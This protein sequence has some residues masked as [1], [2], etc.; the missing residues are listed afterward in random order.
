MVNLDTAY[1]KNSSVSGHM[2]NIYT[3]TLSGSDITWDLTQ[4]VS[5]GTWIYCI[6][7]TVYINKTIISESGIV[8]PAA[9]INPSNINATNSPTDG[10]VAVKGAGIDEF[11]WQTF[12]SS[13]SVLSNSDYI[14]GES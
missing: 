6:N 11:T 13:S 7:G 12:S 4:T 1:V 2:G 5:A 8:L 3:A 10:Q 9:V 14:V